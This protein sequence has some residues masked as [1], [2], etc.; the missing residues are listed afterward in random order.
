M[1]RRGFTLIELLVVIAIIAILAAILFPVFAKAR[2]KARQSSCSSNLKQI[3]LGILSYA[4]DYDEKFPLALE[5]ALAPGGFYLFT[6]TI[7][8][9]IKNAQIWQCPSKKDA[10]VLTNIGKANQGYSVDIATPMPSGVYRLFG[11]P[12][13]PVGTLSCSL[14]QIDQ[15]AQ[16]A[17]M[18][19]VSGS[20]ASDFTIAIG[21]D[22]RHNDGCN[23][24]FCDGHVKWDRPDRVAIG[25]DM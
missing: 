14:G 19:D 10:L 20:I 1:K 8:P 4:Q 12:P 3:G 13:A 15:P 25:V 23:Y 11:I 6:E 24:S 16:Q 17:M 7:N 5:G 22:P 21:E 18:C 2:E 9:Y